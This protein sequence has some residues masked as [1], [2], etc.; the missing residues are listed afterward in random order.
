M[1]LVLSL[2]EVTWEEQQVQSAV[3]SGLAGARLR[4]FWG[5]NY[6]FH[7]DDLP[8]KLERM[9]SVFTQFRKLVETKCPVRDVLPV[10]DTLKPL[11]T[12]IAE[13]AAR[14]GPSHPITLCS[15][16]GRETDCVCYAV[17]PCCD[18]R[19]RA[20]RACRP[21]ASAPRMS[22]QPRPPWTR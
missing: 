20:C 18:Q 17:W 13:A 9:P 19:R 22:R 3:K 8:F 7:I 12:A 5:G 11:P 21:W 10:P 2:S 1:P 4:E 15:F 6:L 14:E 16:V